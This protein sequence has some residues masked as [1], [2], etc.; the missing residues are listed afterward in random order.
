MR[1]LAV[2]FF[3]VNALVAV[4]LTTSVEAQKPVS[5]GH[6]DFTRDIRPILSDSC[7]HCHGP[8]ESTRKAKM[9][10]D[11]KEGILAERRGR[12]PV[13]PGKP[14]DSEIVKRIFSN[15]PDEQM[16]P[17]DYARQPTAKQKEQLKAWIAQGAPWEDHWAFEKP[18][19]PELPQ[20]KNK[21][22]P[23]N[24]I[25]HF[26]LERLEAEKLKPSQEADKATLLRR[27]TL[28]LTGLPPTP[29]EIRAFQKDKSS[30]AYERVVDRLLAS[31][32]Y[33]ERMAV[34][35]L[36]LARYAD[37]HGYQVDRERIMWPWRDWV[38]KAFNDNM[39][40]D[41]FTVEQLAGDLLPNATLEQKIATGFHRNQRINMEGGSI[42]EEFF[43]EQVVD[44]VDTTATVWMGLT[45]GCARCHDHK[46]DPVSAKDFYS[47]YAFFNNI[48]ERGVDRENVQRNNIVSTRPF[49]KL[50]APE[51]EAKLAQLDETIAAKQRVVDGITATLSK[52]QVAWEKQ[53]LT[54]A[55]DWKNLTVI[56][57]K[58]ESGKPVLK[59]SNENSIVTEGEIAEADTFVVV[60]QT[61]LTN[62]NGIRL[63]VLPI[64]GSTNQLGH[65]KDG[66]FVLN[67]L[68]LEVVAKA[69]KRL[70]SVEFSKVS[71]S[72]ARSGF[73]ATLLLRPRENVIGGWSA[74]SKTGEPVDVIFETKESVSIPAGATLKFKLTQN[75]PGK[76]QMG[77][78]RLTATDND[79]PSPLSSALTKIFK[80]PVEK[81][82]VAE[83]KSASDYFLSYQAE[84]RTA[85]EGMAQMNRE[86]K[87]LDDQ[88]PRTMVMEELDKPRD[89]FIL[90]RGAYDQP[91]ERVFPAVP[92]IL[93]QLEPDA[94]TN[95]LGLAQWL[96]SPENPLTARVTVNRFWA[97]YFGNGLV[98]TIED[99]G[100]QGDLPSH[101]G[102][103]DWLAT[104]F[105]RVGW[106]TKAMQKLLVMSAT[107]RQASQVSED[108]LERDPENILLARGS[109]MRLPAEMIRDQALSFSGLISEKMGGPSVKPY[110]PVGLWEELAAGAEGTG[111]ATYE[112]GK[113][114]DLYRR[115][116]YTF[117][118]RTV[119]PP[120]MSTFDAPTREICTVSRSRTST[121][122]QAL[123]LLNDVTYVEAARSLAQRMLR[124]GGSSVEQRI[125][126]GFILATARE[127]KKAEMT[128]LKTGLEQRLAEMKSDRA[129]A[130]QLISVGDSKADDK[131]NA[132][133]L[134]AY[135]T[136]ASVIL[137][138]DEV[139]TK[140]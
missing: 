98:K 55:P 69:G 127:P 121:P 78:F 15:D 21:K 107:Y 85:S 62:I 39:P 126:H 14:D 67:T 43:V 36:D 108:L 66:T 131:L 68:N 10:F 97:A 34:D 90:V 4:V 109:R 93:P 7:F 103:L 91:G 63:E 48:A 57:A 106:D 23:R 114:E 29:E 18:V 110:Q 133:E 61:E 84:Y 122:L 112:Q 35:W 32:R 95:R 53:V 116:L 28:D 30:K 54:N 64:P 51:L 132:S 9:R 70:Q 1:R 75:N 16:P 59:A 31:P 89:A 79:H 50:P 49:L 94:P 40:F 65:S 33:G 17:P 102:L 19:R 11:T 87:T 38:I 25:D 46:Y 41:Q 139:I 134:A 8:D 12:F 125:R 44:R 56:E 73:A 20:V 74:E 45:V 58:A 27:V 136:V 129:A 37:T 22:W 24:E 92:A 88:I 81:R 76:T 128:I 99:F 6:V 82:K 118:K 137:N 123:A 60:A 71:G 140:Q 26:I 101:P 135:T 120:A 100:M 2:K 117:W 119:S 83:V 113:G 124:E 80:I 130:E 104:E 77:H 72:A 105:M 115:S 52:Q 111:F 42:A 47:M 13:V 138:L 96:I 86:R 3:V 5:A